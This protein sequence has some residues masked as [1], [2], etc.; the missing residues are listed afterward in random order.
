L[1]FRPPDRR[2]KQKKQFATYGT[3]KIG[4]RPPQL[5]EMID[6]EPL[7][8]LLDTIDYLEPDNGHAPLHGSP[9]ASD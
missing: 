4:L 8:L 7:G 5:R 3:Q 2:G 1:D 6:L 9:M